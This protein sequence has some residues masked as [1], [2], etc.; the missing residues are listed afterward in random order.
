MELSTNTSGLSA[1]LVLAFSP[2][3]AGKRRLNPAK[4]EG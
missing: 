2:V 3:A 4:R 1:F